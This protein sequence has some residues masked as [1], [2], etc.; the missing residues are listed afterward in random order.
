MVRDG[1]LLPDKQAITGDYYKD[2]CDDV[3]V[4]QV[5]Q[6]KKGGFKAIY[7]DNVWKVKPDSNDQNWKTVIEF[8][9]SSSHK[10]PLAKERA[11]EDYFQHQ[12]A[13][14]FNRFCCNFWRNLTNQSVEKVVLKIEDQINEAKNLR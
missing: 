14:L 11:L 6:V 12:I 10:M 13:R 3:P 2:Y 8:L 5:E 7:E 4:L 1:G 9:F